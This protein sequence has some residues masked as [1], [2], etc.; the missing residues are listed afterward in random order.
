[1]KISIALILIVIVYLINKF[2]IYYFK[3]FEVINLNVPVAQFVRSVLNE[4]ENLFPCTRPYNLELRYYQPKTVM[5]RY[6][7]ETNTL[8]I[9]ISKSS[10]LLDVTDTII[11]EYCHH[12]QNHMGKKEKKKHLSF[13]ILNTGIIH[14]KRKLEN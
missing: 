12:L 10:K 9:Y 2:E 11:H 8:V 6:F 3:S 4:T 13:M 1:M 7:Y 5:G 14:G